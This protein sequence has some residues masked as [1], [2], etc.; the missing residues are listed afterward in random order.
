MFLDV[1]QNSHQKFHIGFSSKGVK[2]SFQ[3][4]SNNEKDKDSCISRLHFCVSLGDKDAVITEL[5]IKKKVKEVKLSAWH[6]AR[7]NNKPET[8]PYVVVLS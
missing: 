4:P 5:F 1:L 3:M 2:K 6:T 7:M 8:S